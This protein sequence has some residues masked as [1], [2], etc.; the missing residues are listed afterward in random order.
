MNTNQRFGLW[1]VV[2]GIVTPKAD[3]YRL[4][5]RCDCG[6]TKMVMK[7]PLLLGTTKSCGCRGVYP[8]GTI[9]GH[10]VLERN[11]RDVVLRCQHGAIFT[12]RVA[13]GAIRMQTCPCDRDFAKH[14]KHGEASHSHRSV[15]YN[16]WRQMRQ[17]CNDPKNKHYKHYGG[18]G[19]RVCER[20]DEFTLFLQDMGRRPEKHSLDRIDVDGNYEPANCRWADAF[21]QRHNQRRC[22]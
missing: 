7:K 6:T 19:I 11:G 17:R 3:G 4:L 9:A 16:A 2:D 12:S 20:W 8:G 1:T 18:R 5:C 13:N 22:K 21:T 14:A 15:E 10:V